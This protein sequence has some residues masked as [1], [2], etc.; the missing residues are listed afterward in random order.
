MNQKMPNPGVECCTS[1][2]FNWFFLTPYSLVNVCITLQKFGKIRQASLSLQTSSGEA[3]IRLQKLQGHLQQWSNLGIKVSYPGSH[4]KRKA[5]F[6]STHVN[7]TILVGEIRCRLYVLCF[8]CIH[9]FLYLLSKA[10]WEAPASCDFGITPPGDF[11][12]SI[13]PQT[14]CGVLWWALTCN[15]GRKLR[16][17]KR[18]EKRRTTN[19]SRPFCPQRKWEYNCIHRFI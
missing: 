15:T 10:V 13:A 7:A 12:D 11:V 16:E 2:G 4:I 5:D 17:V 18:G 14:C 1:Q 9:T 3:H 19:F 8:L 6:K